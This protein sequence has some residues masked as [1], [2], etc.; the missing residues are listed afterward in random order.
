MSRMLVALVLFLLA[1]SPALADDLGADFK[2]LCGLVEEAQTLGDEP[3]VR[4]KYVWDNLR[5][6]VESEEVVD[7]Y[8][9]IFQVDPSK[10]YRVFKQAAEANM[11]DSWEC[12]AFKVLVE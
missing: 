5:H 7:A 10:R 6:R 1:G 9:A 3:E 8:E 11:A 4:A 12:P 2:R